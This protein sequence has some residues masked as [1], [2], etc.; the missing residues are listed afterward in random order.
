MVVVVAQSPFICQQTHEYKEIQSI[1][2]NTK[3]KLDLIKKTTLKRPA[4]QHGHF[5]K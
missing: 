1:I 4:R 2:I 5:L 3:T